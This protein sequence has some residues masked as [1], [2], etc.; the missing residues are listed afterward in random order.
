M[1]G[2]GS[3]QHV[4]DNRWVVPYN[5]ALLKHFNCH[6]N[7]EYCGSIRAIKYIYKYIYKGYDRAV[8]STITK[9]SLAIPSHCTQH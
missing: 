3:R 6:I 1:V 2:S 8:V 5:P 7:V 9:S 4:V